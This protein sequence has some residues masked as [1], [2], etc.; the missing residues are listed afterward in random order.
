MYYWVTILLDDI[1]GSTIKIGGVIMTQK[2]SFREGGARKIAEISKNVTKTPRGL[3]IIQRSTVEALGATAS[4]G[5]S[6]VLRKKGL[7]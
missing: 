6:R 1:D 4:S 2:T 5:V 3:E 7:K